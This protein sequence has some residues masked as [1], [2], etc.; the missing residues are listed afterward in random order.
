MDRHRDRERLLERNS[1]I[2]F[3]YVEI[4]EYKLLYET[5]QISMPRNKENMFY[6]HLRGS[7]IVI[8]KTQILNKSN[9]MQIIFRKVKI[10]F[11]FKIFLK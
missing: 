4:E 9:K 8:Q 3:S 5:S 11:K 7:S 6:M 2:G 1:G 10:H